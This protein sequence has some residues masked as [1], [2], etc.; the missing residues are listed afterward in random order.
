MGIYGD[1]HVEGGEGVDDLYIWVA[2]KN[3]NTSKS[4]L[5]KSTYNPITNSGS[6]NGVW[7]TSVPT[8]INS[9]QDLVA[10]ITNPVEMEIEYEI[11]KAIGSIDISKTEDDSLAINGNNINSPL[12]D[13][14]FALY[15]EKGKEI[16]RKITN[17]NGKIKFEGLGLGKY[18]IKEVKAPEGYVIDREKYN[19]E[20]NTPGQIIH[21]NEGE[22]K[23]KVVKGQ[24]ELK[25]IGGA[26]D[27]YLKD[28]EFTIYSDLN[29]NR[30]IDIKDKKVETIRTNEN[31]YAK[32]NYLKFGNYIITETKAPEGYYL[33]KTNFLFE[34]DRDREIVSINNN[35]PIF[36]KVKKNI[37]KLSKTGSANFFG[38]LFHIL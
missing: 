21:L 28:A 30:I 16:S 9:G 13:A 26:E 25:K 4:P 5:I 31:G 38:S 23:N 3:E 12:S 20:I 27:N 19:F 11:E 1:Y 34:I 6:S 36:D 33:N 35:K 24:V 22:V 37:K 15:D 32:S 8:F 10:G 18:S 2:K 14:F 7:Y 29:N 17:K